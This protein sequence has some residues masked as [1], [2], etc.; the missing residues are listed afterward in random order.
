[1]KSFELHLLTQTVAAINARNVPAA[2]KGPE[3]VTRG[4]L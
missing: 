2:A 3:A 4:M 1:M